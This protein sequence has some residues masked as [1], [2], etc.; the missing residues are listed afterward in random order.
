MKYL[1]RF[2]SWNKDSIIQKIVSERRIASKGDYV[3]IK[4]RD[5]DNLTNSNFDRDMINLAFFINNN[6]GKIVFARGPFEEAINIKYNNVPL[7]LEEYFDISAPGMTTFEPSPCFKKFNRN[8]IS[9]FATPEEIEEFD[10]RENAN[11]YNL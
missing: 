6:I 7:N 4:I 2:E 10:L 3:R 5:K 8:Q 9:S 1:K 11:K